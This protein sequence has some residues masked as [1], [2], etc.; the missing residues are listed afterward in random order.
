LLLDFCNDAIKIQYPFEG[1]DTRI[2]YPFLPAVKLTRFGVKKQLQGHNI[3]THALN[4]VKQLFITDNRTGC[5]FITVDADNKPR[6]IQFYERN[7]FNLLTNQDK[8]RNQRAM[9]FDLKR[10]HNI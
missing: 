6:V 7:G 5:H 10:F 8:G 9:F 4:M 2:H 1:V 3:G